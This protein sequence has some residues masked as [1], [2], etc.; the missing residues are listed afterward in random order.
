MTKSTI[1][2]IP[3]LKSIPTELKI[4]LE[5]D[6]R[7]NNVVDFW[8]NPIVVDCSGDTIN[9]WSWGKNGMDDQGWEDDVFLSRAK[10]QY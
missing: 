1:D 7:G 4:L 2:V 8:G 10:D 6:K 5:R 9:V 3:L